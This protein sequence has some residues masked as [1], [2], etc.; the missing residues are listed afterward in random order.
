M[1]YIKRRVKFD[2]FVEHKT[3]PTPVVH[4]QSNIRGKFIKEVFLG[5]KITV[6]INED[7][8]E[9]TYETALKSVLKD[10]L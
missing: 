9:G 1:K 3:V 2:R 6:Y 5:R 8:Y 7:E 4:R 10:N